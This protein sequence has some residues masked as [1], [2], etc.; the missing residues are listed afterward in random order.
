MAETKNEVT[1]KQKQPTFSM[2]L[3][4]KLNSVSEALPKDFNKSR[5]VQNALALINDNPQLQ[6]YNQ[7]QLMAGLLKGAYLGLDFYSKECYL[8]PYGNQLNYQTDY[9][10]A[11][12]LAKKYSI[13]PIKDIY[14]KLVREGDLFEETIENGEQT[15]NFKPKAFNDGKVIGAFAV[16]LYK[17]GGISYETMSLADLENTRSA[18]KAANSP[19]WKKFTGEMYKKTVLHRL[20][21]HIELDFEN[22]TQ[23]TTFY[24]GVEIET[25]VEDEVKTEIEENANTV[26]FVPEA[27][28]TVEEPVPAAVVEPEIPD[29]M[30]QEEM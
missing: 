30:K 24:S 22:P 25:N 2:V 3:T 12:K 18:S 10:G 7:S 5:F 6:K 20:C 17:D 28:V 23:Q 21:K 16:V 19:A 4:D 11:K 8:V 9:R 15:F 13:R 14:A 1:T 29:F 26:D 27:D